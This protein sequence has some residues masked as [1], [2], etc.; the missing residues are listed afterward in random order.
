[1]AENRVVAKRRVP[2]LDEQ[3]AVKKV[4]ENGSAATGLRKNGFEGRR[5]TPLIPIV[6]DA[7]TLPRRAARDPLR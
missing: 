6:D 2:R 7:S 1:M 3:L 5:T 4:V